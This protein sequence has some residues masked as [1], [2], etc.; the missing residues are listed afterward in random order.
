[1]FDIDAAIARLEGEKRDDEVI[2]FGLCFDFLKS[3][4]ST[5][6]D[7][8]RMDNKLG[9]I[10]QCEGFIGVTPVEDGRILLIFETLANAMK[11]QNYLTYKN[12]NVGNIVPILIDEIYYKEYLDGK[13]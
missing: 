9:K 6:A 12:I 10:K 7:I 4:F 11:A 13:Q 8:K 5:P 2:V 1:M 3:K